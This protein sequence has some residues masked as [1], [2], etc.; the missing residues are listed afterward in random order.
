MAKDAPALRQRAEALA[1]TLPPL[2]GLELG[3]SVCARSNVA[4][5]K[6]P[7]RTMRNVNVGSR[8]ADR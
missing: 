5:T 4:M 8:P 2:P 3:K 1:S 6:K 7:P